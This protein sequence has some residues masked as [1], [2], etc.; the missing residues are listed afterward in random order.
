MCS[1]KLLHSSNNEVSGY[2]VSD[3]IHSII[4]GTSNALP[5]IFFGCSTSVA[6]PQ[7]RLDG[8]FGF[9]RQS[10]SVINQLY[11][12]GV[13]PHVF[14]H[15]LA[16]SESVTGGGILAIGYPQ[17]P[18]IVYTP[19]VPDGPDV[20]NFDVNL[21]SISVNHRTLPIN[22]STFQQGRTRFDSGTSM[23]VAGLFPG[24][25]LNFADNASMILG[26]QDY[27]VQQHSE[28]DFEV[29]CIGFM[30]S[31]N[32]DTTL[33]DLLLRD[34]LIVYD[35][36]HQR[37]GWADYNCAKLINATTAPSSGV[38][39]E[40][41]ILLTHL[42]IDIGSLLLTENPVEHLGAIGVAEVKITPNTVKEHQITLQNLIFL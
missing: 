8:V 11:T 32:Q 6:Q 36:E 33:G 37:I 25:T 20:I 13:A 41:E 3:V 18:K 22:Q 34:K 5:T 14:S 29:W 42:L 17:E 31:T 39:S 28:G 10:F 2:Y 38:A 26:Q 21:E 24:V 15:C 1:Y 30:E 7:G 23:A 40:Q 19:L 27:L 12:Q 35:L 4:N 16:G 9:G